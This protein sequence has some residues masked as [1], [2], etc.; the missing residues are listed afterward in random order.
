L[1]TKWLPSNHFVTKLRAQHV[2]HDGGRRRRA[3]YSTVTL[4]ARLRGRSTSR[5]RARAAW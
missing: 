5:P 3:G 2:G 4:L 1:G